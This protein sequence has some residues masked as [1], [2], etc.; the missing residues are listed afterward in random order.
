VSPVRQILHHDPDTTTV[1]LNSFQ[2]LN[3]E[4]KKHKY[5]NSIFNF[6]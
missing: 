4:P 6:I 3:L 5:Q 1:I 2:D